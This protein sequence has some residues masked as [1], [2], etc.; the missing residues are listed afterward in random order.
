[1][2]EAETAIIYKLFLV[3]VGYALGPFILYLCLLLWDK[4]RDWRRDKNSTNKSSTTYLGFEKEIELITGCY[5][6]QRGIR[7]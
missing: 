4:L 1:M 5:D 3:L 6:I 2:S 7:N